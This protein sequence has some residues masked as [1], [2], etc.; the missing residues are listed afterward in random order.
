MAGELTTDKP[1]MAKVHWWRAKNVWS[2][3]FSDRC[4]HFP[5]IV[6][7]ARLE[8]VLNDKSSP[9]AYFKGRIRVVDHGDWAELI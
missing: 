6:I 2:I 5:K 1:R 9:K 4:I 8:S 3:V 7:N